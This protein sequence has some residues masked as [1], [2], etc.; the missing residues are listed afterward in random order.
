VKDLLLSFKGELEN[1]NF[2]FDN[3]IKSIGLFPLSENDFLF[4]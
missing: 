2:S 3:D 1:F 4:G